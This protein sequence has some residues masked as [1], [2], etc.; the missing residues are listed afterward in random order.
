MHLPEF[1]LFSASSCAQVDTDRRVAV[2]S[3]MSS[4]AGADASS[5]RLYT[6]TPTDQT[7]FIVIATAVGLAVLPVFVLIRYLVRR[8][9]EIGADDV[10]LLT[11]SALSIAQSGVILR[12]SSSGLGRSTTEIQPN[13]V[14][15]AEQVWGTLWGT[16]FHCCVNAGAPADTSRISSYII[17]APSFGC[18]PSPCPRLAQ[19]VCFYDSA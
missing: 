8:S 1:T 6:V 14:A 11:L 13:V 9:T 17:Q 3:K 16:F 15:M 10:L 5:R 19:R 12:A 4:A 2:L 18:Y 7:A